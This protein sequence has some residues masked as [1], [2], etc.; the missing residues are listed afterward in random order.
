MNTPAMPPTHSG[1]S[2]Q[3]SPTF[4]LLFGI[5]DYRTVDPERSVLSPAAYFVDLMRVQHAYIQASQQGLTLK[6][7]RPD[8]WE[9]VLDG[10]NTTTLVPKL[11][12]VNKILKEKLNKGNL[13]TANYPLA[14]P[15]NEFL[16]QIKI[17]LAQNKTSLAEIR[18]NLAKPGTQPDA[19]TS[20]RQTLN[21]SP[22]QWRLFSTP[23]G[24][25][26]GSESTSSP[27]LTLKD[28]ENLYTLYGLAYT[29]EKAANAASKLKKTANKLV[30]SLSSVGTF[31]AQT[32]LTIEKLHNLLFQNLSDEE[33]KGG[34]NNSF[35]INATG[36]KGKAA[37]TF[38]KD[39]FLIDVASEA[40]KPYARL[41]LGNELV[42]KAS[43]STQAQTGLYV[44]VIHE[45]T[46]LVLATRCYG[47]GSEDST[48]NAQNMMRFSQDINA[49]P[50]GRIVA[51]VVCGNALTTVL[52]STEARQAI[53]DLGST[54][55][56]GPKMSWYLIGR[57]GG[58]SISEGLLKEGGMYSTRTWM[59]LP[60]GGL[61]NVTLK[62]LERINRF[63]RLA[64]ALSWSFGD[65]DQALRTI[66]QIVKSDGSAV[67]ND[68]VLPYLA[69]INNLQQ[70]DAFTVD[71]ACGLL[72]GL[73]DFGEKKGLS[74][75]DQ[76]FSNQNV[77]NPP[78][79]YETESNGKK[80]Y[81]LQWALPD[82]GPSSGG[83]ASTASKD[84][85]IQNALA[86][87]L[88]LDG[89]DLLTLARCLSK[90]TSDPSVLSLSLENLSILY[91]LSL[92]PQ[93]T[94]L[95]IKEILVAAEFIPLASS[96]PASTKGAPSGIKDL[97]F[98]ASG[99][100]ALAGI[101]ALRDFV[102]W[103]ATSPFSVFQLQFILKGESADPRVQ[104]KMLGKNALSNAA[105]SLD[106]FLG[107]ASLTQTN[108]F[109]AIK[110]DIQQ[111]FVRVLQEVGH[112][113]PE[114]LPQNLMHQT[115][116][117]A[118]SY[119]QEIA[120]KLYGALQPVFIDENAIVLKVVGDHEGHQAKSVQSKLKYALLSVVVGI[121]DHDS[122]KKPVKEKG[123]SEAL[124]A[125]LDHITA[126]LATSIMGTVERFYHLQQKTL[127]EHLAALCRVS[128]PMAVVLKDWGDLNASA[129][130]SSDN[131]SKAEVFSL[132][133]VLSN[134]TGKPEQA[135][136]ILHGLQQLAELL[137]ILGLSA[138]E[139][140][141]FKTQYSGTNEYPI[142]FTEIQTMQ[143]FMRLKNAFG[144]TQNNLIGIL[145]GASRE[146]SQLARLS[147]WQ[148]A[149]INFLDQ[150]QSLDSQAPSAYTIHEIAW[151]YR[152]IHT[153]HTLGIDLPTLLRLTEVAPNLSAKNNPSHSTSEL[154]NA[155][156]AGL[157]KRCRQQ[158]DVLK[159]LRSR[160]NEA[161]RDRLVPLV[162]HQ[163][164]LSTPR[165]LYEYL[166]IDV[167]VSGLVE[168]SPIKE[169][170]SAQQLYIYRCL[171]HLEANVTV[172]P[173][174]N[175]LWKWMYAYRHWQANREVFLYPEDYIQP[176]L[177]KHK[178]DLFAKLEDDLKQADLTDPNSITKLFQGYMNGFAK[179]SGLRIIGAGTRDSMDGSMTIKEI[180]MVGR[181]K[182]QH[183]GTYFRVATFAKP[184]GTTHFQPLH[185]GQWKKMEVQIVPST[186]TETSSNTQEIQPV[187]TPV[188]AFGRWYVFW[189]KQEHSKE[190]LL[191]GTLPQAAALL[192]IKAKDEAEKVFDL[193]RDDAEPVI[194]TV[195]SGTVGQLVDTVKT[196]TVGQL[197]NT[198]A[199]ATVAPLVD[200]VESDTAAPLVDTVAPETVES[201]ASDVAGADDVNAVGIVPEMVVPNVVDRVRRTLM[202]KA[203]KT[204]GALRDNLVGKGEKLSNYRPA[205][206]LEKLENSIL[207]KLEDDIEKEEEKAERELDQLKDKAE[208]EALK[209][210]DKAEKEALKLKDKAE[211]DALKLKEKAEKEALK[212]KDEVEH[213]VDELWSLGERLAKALLD[214]L[215]PKYKVDICYSYQD[216][217]GNWGAAETLENV[218][219]Q[220]K[221]IASGE[222]GR[223]YPVF[224]SSIETLYI[225]FNEQLYSLTENQLSQRVVGANRFESVN[226]PQLMI[227]PTGCK[228]TENDKG[229][230]KC[231]A[232]YRALGGQDVDGAQSLSTW[233]KLTSADTKFWG[234]GV[235][236]N[237]DSSEEH[238]AEAVHRMVIKPDTWY[239]LA[240]SNDHIFL[241]G[242][243]T[244]PIFFVG[245]EDGLFSRQA[246]HSW[247]QALKVPPEKRAGFRGG[248]FCLKCYNRTL[249]VG[250]SNGLYIKSNG[251]WKECRDFSGAS[252]HFVTYKNNTLYVGS[253]KGLHKR[254]NE[255]WQKVSS[256]THDTR[257]LV[258]FGK[259]LYLGS[260]RGLYC[261]EEN[262]TW[263]HVDS[264]TDGTVHCIKVYK[265]VVY[266]GTEN[267]VYCKEEG[268][269]WSQA[270]SLKEGA[271]NCLLVDK[272]ILYAGTESG[273]Y[274]L[275]DESWQKK[276]G[277]ANVLSLANDDSTLYAGASD[278]LYTVTTKDGSM[279]RIEVAPPGA[280]RWI[281]TR[282]PD[283]S[284][285]FM[286]QA[287]ETI[288]FSQPLTEAQIQELYANSRYS[289][290]HDYETFAPDNTFSSRF[291]LTTI[292][293]LNQ[294]NWSII[295]SD[296]AE[297]LLT[298]FADTKGPQGQCYRLNSTAAT[299]LG[300]YMHQ[301][302]GIN[303]VLSIHAQ[304]LA[305]TAFENLGP[306]AF[307]PS[308]TW[309]SDRIDYTFKS[310]MSPYYWELFFHTPFLIARELQTH[311]QFQLAE[312]WFQYIFNPRVPHNT[313]DLEPDDG[314]AQDR[315][316]SFL[317][318]RSWH[319][320]ALETELFVGPTTEL[321]QGINDRLEVY[322]YQ[323]DP[324]D[325]QEIA[326]L[327]PIAYQ[328][329]I[330]MHYVDN[331]MQWGDMLFRENTRE[332]I[333]E[334]EMF[335]V[336]AYDLLGEHPHN[337]GRKQLPPPTDCAHIQLPLFPE[338]K[339]K[340][341]SSRV[342][343]LP[344]FAIPRNKKFLGYWDT[345][346]QR[347]YNIRHSLDINGN[348]DF[349]PLFQPAIDPMALVG[350]LPTG[351]GV[352][353]PPAT[354]SSV[355]PHYRFSA[356]IERAKA[357]TATA[358]GLGQS[359]L[360][361]LEKK[362]AEKLAILL[363]T[364]E[365][366]ILELSRNSKQDQ[367]SAAEQS[368]KAL[369]A[370]LEGARYREQ[371]YA[372][373][374]KSGYSAW[375]IVQIALSGGAIVVQT[376]GDASLIASQ[377]AHLIPTIY[378]FS[379]GGM[380]P[381]D[382]VEVGSKLTQSISQMMQQGAGIAGTVAS[383]QR[384]AEDWHLQETMAK[385]D[386]HQINA[387][388]L[389]AKYR[390]SFALQEIS[391]LEKNIAQEKKVADF[392]HQK[393]TNNQLYQ[394]YIGKVAGLYFHAYQLAHEMAVQAEN[395][396]KFEHLGRVS[397]HVDENFI[398]PA[399]WN[400]LYQG[401]LAGENLQL[402][403]QR[404]EK[405]FV[406]QNER[407]LEI[408]KT[409]A[410]SQLDPGA[411]FKLKQSGCCTFDF[412]EKDF[413]FDFPGHYCRKIT[414]L[415]VSLPAVIGPYQN[416]HADLTQLTNKIVTSDDENGQ[417]AVTYLLGKT[418]K[419]PNKALKVDVR[420]N[421]QIALSQGTSDNGLFTLNFND[422]RYLPFEGTG[423]V[424]S[425]R[426][427]MPRED[428]AFDF[429]TI[430]DV[431]FEL[432]YTALAGSA[433][434]KSAV[435]GAR[436]D[437]NGYR[438]ISLAGNPGWTGFVNQDKS[439]P[440]AITV[441]PHRLRANMGSYRVTGL[442]L[443]ASQ[444]GTSNLNDAF[445]EPKFST[446]SPVEPKRQL[447]VRQLSEAGVLGDIF[448]ILRNEPSFVD[449]LF[450][451]AVGVLRVRDT[452]TVSEGALRFR[453]IIPPFI[454]E[455]RARRVHHS[456]IP[457]LL[458]ENQHIRD[459]MFE[460][461]INDE[462]LHER[463]TNSLS[464]TPEARD[465][466]FELLHI[467]PG[468]RD[469]I[470]PPAPA[471]IE[472]QAYDAPIEDGR[473]GLPDVT[474]QV[475]TS[476]V[477]FSWDGTVSTGMLPQGSLPLDPDGSTP[478]KLSVKGTIP[479]SVK[480]ILLIIDFTAAP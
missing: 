435:R 177:R 69:W 42:F 67:I 188:F 163:L 243:K 286:C 379:D 203:K 410:L 111:V 446:E 456:R 296:R 308:E 98:S 235:Q 24:L 179:V 36:E 59:V 194:H 240:M 222:D 464:E 197:V 292:P 220:E 295:E 257:C 237:K 382:A 141:F 414:T 129:L 442:K 164:G 236:P 251:S 66:G 149:Q 283:I 256:V 221:P 323:T 406:D 48:A 263:I 350:A 94:R 268:G 212:L 376:L 102:Q 399:Y 26:S 160:L 309:P 276:N 151:M 206:L 424:S 96:S 472:G 62:R 445:V 95:S 52:K 415:S 110:T 386:I 12:I 181:T 158:P 228:P 255:A 277:H 150:I 431:I 423:A 301:P 79:W 225:M 118:F 131:K 254:V 46:G 259:T 180:A 93:L 70:K 476:N 398:K 238:K 349:L 57:K 374:I 325:P 384:R 391:L 290:T 450:R 86:A 53:K 363:Q 76:V 273:L 452:S 114:E 198:V 152:Y 369:E 412:T 471:S 300:E 248:V 34:C 443:Y 429:D 169:G 216:F 19:E 454:E 340:P 231:V 370:G 172:A 326:A 330:V 125:D 241:N 208:N 123:I 436:G 196:G 185:W 244:R 217:H 105:Q 133:H 192:M 65:L 335:Y 119:H 90:T 270:A 159:K 227:N 267:G 218:V 3:N 287:Q 49:L 100:D 113:F 321:L 404:M 417:R 426:L 346:K 468:L 390:Q 408:N 138:A 80:S 13:A 425:W 317:G 148:P 5:E 451:F 162:M 470:F 84:H 77:S 383:Y 173:I 264:V 166:L 396:W 477:S 139:A 143:W 322:E 191:S 441:K 432:K 338:P 68:K 56:L 97:L 302:D 54:K 45:Q 171:Q 14:L 73:R 357:V 182:A 213:E 157:Q 409:I 252:V 2:M 303:A 215:E 365:Q 83:G 394:W 427:E 460:V 201:A 327:R 250:T 289:V 31:V 51:V 279:N 176:Q 405:A 457:Y 178:T 354:L 15:Y 366:H 385:H 117:H 242:K 168:T 115:L 272:G 10:H 186:Y 282:F 146:M 189:T 447:D 343:C 27:E 78:Q 418:K 211:K 407:R 9:L 99:K 175:R 23:Y 320:P 402:D 195:A 389:A 165:A 104:N 60:Q 411:L 35:Y 271:V 37:V 342:W 375:E 55:T 291:I 145:S 344:Y 199:P 71:Q 274:V 43:D 116:A 127:I 307:I 319:N 89:D 210:K 284:P 388:I 16:E 413:D 21:L 341:S 30:D 339:D 419:A 298:P 74:F 20:A 4:Q 233:F 453:E 230:D 92:L 209:L 269:T 310:A 333:V 280:I 306:T 249:Y 33:I 7:R 337:L 214:S 266:A 190:Q 265:N 246:D 253:N 88:K 421:Q 108:F 458:I 356:M 200:T 371:H 144:D 312:R 299:N 285:A 245:T 449:K 400:N 361:A 368:V 474:L 353:K 63:V 130:V 281:G 64:R 18:E 395:A 101:K 121:M 47:T 226:L 478:W 204:I 155:L 161:L 32:G 135:R 107:Q 416:I 40:N 137:T 422:E 1:N 466:L 132:L 324:Y 459:D 167:E 434:F 87:A 318:L 202:G 50:E 351:E 122:A 183:G 362:D 345:V 232:Y 39:S 229:V 444:E 224:F 461:V 44:A 355:I 8:L 187:V 275:Q 29:D 381:G 22:E 154:A 473:F 438:V 75:F 305:E 262:A 294:P 260:V 174:L 207:K 358:I 156:W 364:N 28:V 373:L 372:D 378:G 41:Q 463:F 348:P 258:A 103:L 360:S 437:F 392:Y 336:A 25:A 448:H 328:K 315:F 38:T 136:N 85:K 403:L 142:C 82:Q 219:L 112:S 401:L 124:D 359:L 479:K 387:Q 239:H 469:Y 440:L 393:F 91:R 81:S 293:V 420:P 311:H 261:K 6:L 193:V 331:L 140:A 467:E 475:G 316:W 126:P 465:S 397:S 72:G 61:R 297:Y 170:I 153:S 433:P 332:S 120:K 367:L 288:Y 278:G 184:E 147:G 58:K 380:R 314:N 329:T 377:V 428:N 109:L 480:N 234:A 205:A 247:Y 430:T 455:M 347:L 352:E 134:R 11:E 128:S 106:R 17:Y 313:W 462:S 304:C 439:S 223:L 334:A